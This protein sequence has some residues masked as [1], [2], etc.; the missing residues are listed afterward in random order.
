MELLPCATCGGAGEATGADADGQH[1]PTNLGEL[2]YLCLRP[3]RRAQLIVAR[4]RIVKVGR[5]MVVPPQILSPRVKQRALEF[6][7]P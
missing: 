3:E 2:L 5:A 1:C 7:Q 6:P 4:P